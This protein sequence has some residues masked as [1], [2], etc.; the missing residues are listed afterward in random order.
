MDS[1]R[2]DKEYKDFI[3]S[4]QAPA[5]LKNLWKELEPNLPPQKK[6]R[7]FIPFLFLGLGLIFLVWKI[8]GFTFTKTEVANTSISES[9]VKI[10]N[11][12]NQ[13]NSTQNNPTD[14]DSTNDEQTQNDKLKTQAESKPLTQESRSTKLP[15]DQ[16]NLRMGVS[17]EAMVND[18]VP[19]KVQLRN[20]TT[21]KLPLENTSDLINNKITPNVNQENRI[22]PAET[23]TKESIGVDVGLG[24]DELINDPRSAVDFYS[25]PLLSLNQFKLTP[26]QVSMDQVD[27]VKGKSLQEVKTKG[28]SSIEFGASLL[29]PSFRDGSNTQSNLGVELDQYLELSYG[30]KFYVDYKYAFDSGVVVGLGLSS[31]TIVETFKIQE[32]FITEGILFNEEAFKFNDDF[33]GADQ[34]GVT[35]TAYNIF[36]RNSFHLFDLVPSI[37]YRTE[38]RLSFGLDLQALINLSQSYTGS[39]IDEDM[40][41]L[42]SGEL[43]EERKFKRVGGALKA[44]LA[45]DLTDRIQANLNLSYSQRGIIE[46]ESGN[47]N[48]DAMNVIDAGMGLRYS[49]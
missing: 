13:N 29:I 19:S 1:Q 18:A 44:S 48:V 43:F 34:L 9:S 22:V 26:W 36:N 24:K 40:E 11:N 38:G 45:Y 25:L 8:A 4:N 41:L 35:T 3:A 47:F 15:V 20:T 49:F 10:E 14:D 32:E 6:R 31:S 42:K 33:I 27:F 17:R 16:K 39:L 37:G 2:F 21:Q 23:L 30:Y 12:L 7:R 28:G 46:I 5:D